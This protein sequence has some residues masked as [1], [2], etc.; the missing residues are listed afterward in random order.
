[1]GRIDWVLSGDD[2]EYD[3]QISLVDDMI[4]IERD[5]SGKDEMFAAYD[6]D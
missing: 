3:Y 6:D 4:G 2:G 1:M 5:D